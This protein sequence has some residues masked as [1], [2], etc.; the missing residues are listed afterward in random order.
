MRCACVP[1]IH[2]HVCTF[3]QVVYVGCVSLFQYCDNQAQGPWGKEADGVL[4]WEEGEGMDRGQRWSRGF[5]NNRDQKRWLSVWK[6]K[7]YGSLGDLD[8]KNCLFS[9]KPKYRVRITG[10]GSWPCTSF[11]WLAEQ[12]FT[13]SLHFNDALWKNFICKFSSQKTFAKPI[14]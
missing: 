8:E 5:D 11:G 3:S 14:N 1:G 13:C 2:V 10:T 12:M 9:L 6:L 4:G 7:G